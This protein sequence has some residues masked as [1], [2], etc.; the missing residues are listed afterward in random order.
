MVSTREGVALLVNASNRF[1][2]STKLLAPH[3]ATRIWTHAYG[4]FEYPGDDPSVCCSSHPGVRSI[5]AKKES[6]TRKELLPLS[7]EKQ[8]LKIASEV[9]EL[10]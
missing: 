6:L 5:V 2:S 3:V 4:S 7:R 10:S 1:S 9:C 8:C